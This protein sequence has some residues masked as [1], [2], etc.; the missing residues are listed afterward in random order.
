MMTSILCDSAGTALVFAVEAAATSRTQWVDLASPNRA[1][2]RPAVPP[3]QGPGNLEPSWVNF[4]FN[5]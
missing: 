1:T 2:R 4:L 3:F 5:L